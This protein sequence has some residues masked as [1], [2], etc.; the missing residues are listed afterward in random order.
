MNRKRVG[1]SACL[2]GKRVRYDGRGKLDLVVT[3]RLAPWV[4]WVSVCPEVECGLS[5]PRESMRLS[6]DPRD[7]RLVTNETGMDRTELLLRWAE[8]KISE[9]KRNPLSAFVLK[10]G[11]PSCG[12]R[13]I[14]V[15]GSQGRIFL[16][17]TGLFAGLVR[18]RIPGLF[19]EDEIR[20]HDPERMEA[21]LD[22]VFVHGRDCAKYDLSES[23]PAPR[24]PGG[25]RKVR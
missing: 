13:G 24:E 6:G 21:F 4:N 15:T 3:R 11:S 19:C 20:L 7:P 8:R 16:N 1:I 23:P 12:L 18:R 14:P 5:V 25:T 22:A 10:S 2:L 9:F 17:G